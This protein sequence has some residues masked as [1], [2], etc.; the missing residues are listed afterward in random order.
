MMTEIARSLT[1]PPPSQRLKPLKA[2][3][4]ILAIVKA[5]LAGAAYNPDSCSAWAKEIA[6]EVKAKLKGA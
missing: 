5:K 1:E 2:R 4:A 3:E 6:D